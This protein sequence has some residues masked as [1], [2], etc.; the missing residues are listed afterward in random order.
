VK[1]APSGVRNIVLPEIV[2]TLQLPKFNHLIEIIYSTCCADK[3]RLNR[4]DRYDLRIF[5]SLLNTQNTWKR[6]RDMR[7]P[8]RVSWASVAELDQVC[9]WIYTD[10][11]DLDTNT[12]AIN[13][14]RLKSLKPEFIETV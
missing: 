11:H 7:L 6:L 8:R 12:L 10:E 9:S 13:R 3:I 1:E 4:Y 2:I 5:S 14:V